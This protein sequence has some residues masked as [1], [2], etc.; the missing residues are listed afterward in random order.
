MDSL[1][2]QNTI[3]QG[4]SNKHERHYLDFI[5]S[6]K[7]LRKI[8]GVE[9]LDLISTLGWQSKTKYEENLLHVLTLQQK[10]DLTSGRVLL[11]VCAECADINCGAI[12]ANILDLGD[13]IV[14]KDFGYETDYGGLTEEYNIA[15][16]EFKREEYFQA[17]SNFA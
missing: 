1:Q 3:R 9:H 13:R 17:F 14:W 8:L 12:T 5:V 16:I 2:F 15:P 6:G 10:S 11:Y 4:S 7:K